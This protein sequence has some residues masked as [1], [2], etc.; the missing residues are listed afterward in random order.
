MKLVGDGGSGLCNLKTDAQALG[1]IEC[2]VGG[3]DCLVEVNKV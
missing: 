3:G 2:V 1:A